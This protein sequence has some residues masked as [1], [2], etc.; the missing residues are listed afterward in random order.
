MKQKIADA[1]TVFCHQPG[2]PV[3]LYIFLTLNANM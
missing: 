2:V 3:Q 1:A